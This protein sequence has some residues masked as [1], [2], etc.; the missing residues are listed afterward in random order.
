MR[1]KRHMRRCKLAQSKT[2]RIVGW[3]RE[4]TLRATGSEGLRW[5]YLGRC[6]NLERALARSNWARGWLT[7]KSSPVAWRRRRQNR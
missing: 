6:N 2:W 1:I 5:D 3:F 4:S 7:W